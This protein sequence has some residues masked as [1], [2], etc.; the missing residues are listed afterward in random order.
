MINILIDE[1]LEVDLALEVVSNG[2]TEEGVTEISDFIQLSKLQKLNVDVNKII[3][4]LIKSTN[5]STLDIAKS[6]GVSE[7]YI[8]TYKQKI[9]S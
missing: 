3:E 1:L 6:I 2:L 4:N 5:L 7:T 8:L 9:S